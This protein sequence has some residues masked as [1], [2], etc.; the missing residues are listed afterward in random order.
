MVFK[1]MF[2]DSN[3]TPRKVLMEVLEEVPQ[4]LRAAARPME[5]AESASQGNQ[6]SSFPHTSSCD[7][8]LSLCVKSVN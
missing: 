1:I 4:N 6:Y 2:V 8:D 5:Q 7:P 3:S